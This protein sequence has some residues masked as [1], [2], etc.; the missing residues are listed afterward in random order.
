M[1]VNVFIKNTVV[2]VATSLV[3]RTVGIFFRVWQVDKIGSEGMGLYQLIFSVYMLASTF[4]AAGISTAVTRLVADFEHKG[5]AAVRKIMYVASVVTLLVAVLSV[6]LVFFGARHIAVY[7]LKDARAIPSLKILS[8]SLP[9]MGLSSCFR[10][11]FIAR[12]KTVQ[13]SLVQMLEQAVRIAV[14][15]VFVTLF[16]HKGLTYTAAAVLLGDT[17][18]E[19]VS[20]FV[21]WVLYRRDTGKM[22][23]G[24]VLHGVFKSILHIAVPITA[25]SYLGSILHTVESLLVPLKLTVFH[26]T[27]GRGLELFGAIRGMALPVLFFPASFLTSL[28]TMLVPEVSSASAEGNILKVKQTVSKSVSMTLILSTIVACCFMFNASDI[29]FAVYGDRDVGQMILVLS[30]IVPLMY[31]ES[32]TAGLLKGL[33][34][35]MNVLKFNTFD[36]IF[37]IF[38][39]FFIVPNFGI[40]GYLAIM[41]ISNTFT[42]SLSAWCLFRAAD[43]KPDL[44]KWV[45]L[46]L[47]VG[48]VGGFVGKTLASG[49]HNTVL[50]LAVSLGVQMAFSAIAFSVYKRKTATVKT[51]RFG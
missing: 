4:A 13:P 42:S 32:V 29:G 26:G 19:T 39:V 17:A 41:M 9:F 18:A 24:T 49:L 10:G 48:A 22:P 5:R 2:L 7:L 1:K 35:Q 8:L 31:L 3:L 25:T 45:L 23:Q 38:A 28:S 36:S 15:M 34:C 27:K 40:K 50:R 47:C 33:D 30:P 43:I 20:C 12:R 44:G 21:N 37:R 16:A 11:Y 6:A 51:L 46:P 14:V